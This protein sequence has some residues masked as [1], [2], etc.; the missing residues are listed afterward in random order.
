MESRLRY[1]ILDLIVVFYTILWY[2]IATLSSSLTSLSPGIVYISSIFVALLAPAIIGL[3]GNRISLF[4]GSLFYSALCISVLILEEYVIYIGSAITGFGMGLLWVVAPKIVTDN[5]TS[6][7]LQRNQSLFWCIYMMSMVLGNLVEYFYLGGLTVIE[8]HT[9]IIVY[10]VCCAISIAGAFIGLAG[11]RNAEDS[12]HL[13]VHSSSIQ[14]PVDSYRTLSVSQRLEIVFEKIKITLARPMVWFLVVVLI[15]NG[16]MLSFYTMTVET[17][18]G[19]TFTQRKIIPL[20]SLVVGVMEVLGALAFEKIA[21]KIGNGPSTILLFIIASC[22]LYF[23]FLIFPSDS[24]YA[25]NPSDP[26]MLD[27]DPS[28]V[29]FISALI[30]ISDAGFNI[31]ANTY[32]GKLFQGESE[33][34][35]TVLNVT[36]SMTTGCLFFLSPYLS[37]YALLA[38]METLLLT[39][40]LVMLLKLNTCL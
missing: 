8:S 11:I 30:G 32:V 28:I 13:L 25:T 19:A 35:F 7:T 18:I 36:M 26:S 1:P 4:V 17:C 39:A 38:L 9:R 2:S 5:S 6:V 33:I 12:P 23:S 20:A 16:S 21:Q 15:Y 31:L 34:G 29:L 24:T 37:L 14:V 22:S 27:A 10:S 3:T 40:T